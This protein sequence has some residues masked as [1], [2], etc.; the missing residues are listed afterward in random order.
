[1][2]VDLYWNIAIISSSLLGLLVLLNLFGFDVDEIEIDGLGDAFSFNALIAFFCIAG[3]TGYLAHDMTDMGSTLI[4]GTSVAVGIVFYI[5]SIYFLDKLKGIET[6]GNVRIEG[7]IGQTGT[8]YLTIPA[9]QQ[10]DGQIQITIQGGL[11]TYYAQ[12]KGD[13]IPTGEQVLV[14]DIENKKLLVEKY[15]VTQ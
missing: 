6:K 12:T 2:T 13:A 1:M 14:Y 5:V 8:V 3:W 11:R 15:N 9:N 10:G 7:A 4:L